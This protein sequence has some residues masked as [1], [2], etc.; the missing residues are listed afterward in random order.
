MKNDYYFGKIRISEVGKN[1]YFIRYVY[2]LSY[3][4]KCDKIGCNVKF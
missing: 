3:R 4:N 2:V 1:E